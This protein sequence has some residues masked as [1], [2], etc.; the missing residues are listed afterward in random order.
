MVNVAFEL[1]FFERGQKNHTCAGNAYFWSMR[2]LI[3][4]LISINLLAAQI[5]EPKHNKAEAHFL[6]DS[7]YKK[8]NEGSDFAKLANLCSE[9]PGTSG[10]GGL[11][12]NCKKGSLTPEF[13]DVIET[14]KMNQ[15]SK[16]FETPYGFH[17]AKLISKHGDVYSVRH[18]LIRFKEE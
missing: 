14:L 10:K 5:P 7:L 9:D 15:I 4:F 13:E 17:I 16:P 11:Y 6:I 18:I 3:V 8:L 12:S 1:I 2:T